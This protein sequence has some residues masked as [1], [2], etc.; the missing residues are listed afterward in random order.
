MVL[1]N[2]NDPPSLTSIGKKVLARRGQRRGHAAALE[3][4]QRRPT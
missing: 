3:P 4:A 2:A 1:D